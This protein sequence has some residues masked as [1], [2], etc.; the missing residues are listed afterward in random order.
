MGDLFPVRRGMSRG[1]DQ[2]Q[3]D[4][5]FA[6]SREA[7]E[8]GVPA[9]TFS[10]EQIRTA[11]FDMVRGGYAVPQVDSALNRLEVAF[12]QRDRSAFVSEHG[13]NAW[14][15]KVADDATALYPRLLRPAGDRFLHPEGNGQGYSAV[16]VDALL[17]RLAAFFD[18]RGE[19][20]ESEIRTSTFKVTRG[21]KAYNEA[22]VDAYLGRAIQVLMAVS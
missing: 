1:Y 10:S 17:D 22:Q 18:D 6:Q 8:G 11:A 13:E 16:E 5:F 14:F 2:D 20:T 4:S 21:E 9:E 7:Y 15:D 19:V 12:I 3:V